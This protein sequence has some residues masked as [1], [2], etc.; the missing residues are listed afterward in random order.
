MLAPRRC[1]RCATRSAGAQILLKN[2]P[3]RI[4]EY[5]HYHAHPWPEVMAALRAVGVLNMKIFLLGTCRRGGSTQRAT[6]ACGCPSAGCRMFMYMETVDEFDPAV[7]FP[8]HLELNPRCVVVR[9]CSAA[10]RCSRS[11]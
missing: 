4:A 6:H 2:D 1:R 10:R 9:A 8:R 3:A 11:R 7:D 5:R